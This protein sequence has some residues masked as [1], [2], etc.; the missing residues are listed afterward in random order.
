[1]QQSKPNIVFITSDQHRGDTLGCAGHPCVRTPHLDK[2]AMSGVRFDRAYADCPVCIPQRTT[3][4][5]GIQSH[6]YGMPEYA[7]QYRIDRPREL[8]LG[9]LLTRAGYQTQIVGKTH[10]HTE[11]TFR[12]GFEGVEGE[13][14]F[15]DWARA[16]TGIGRADRS[17]IGMNE[18]FPDWSHV[19][20][21]WTMTNWVMD[22]SIRFLEYRDRTQ[23]FFLWASVID[24]HPPNTVHE[25]Y[26]SMYDH[27][28]VPEPNVPEWIHEE[29]CPYGLRRHR[30]VWNSVRMKSKALRKARG[31]YYG[32]V[33]HID[34]QIGRLL[35][36]LRSEGQLDNTWIVYASDHGEMLGDLDDSG[37]STFME[38]SANVPLIICPPRDFSLGLGETCEALVGLDDLFATFCSIA[39]AETPADIT[40]RDLL[41]L[42]RGEAGEVR[43]ELH[44]QIGHSH[45]F[46]T[47]G[48]KYLYF[49]EDGKELLFD[50]VHDRL[51]QHPLNGNLELL[52]SVRE[53]F[54]AHLQEEGNEY[55]A[56]G[57]LVNL[58][59]AQQTDRE[60]RRT[61]VYGWH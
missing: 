56:D 49:A 9:S 35:G 21:E 55:V 16:R 2:L 23:P 31:V 8:F 33:T 28:D 39:G 44:G 14:E 26:Y 54:L 17:G 29:L 40:G 59:V 10:W 3:I 53:R 58:N 34:H 30:E 6:R 52:A 7:Q 11:P 42:I 41:P 48:Y 36:K 38:P 47:G 32:M 61:N 1:M 57:R 19:P 60:L 18:P 20:Q 24:P 4:V 5:T 27:E 25:P 13:A 12:G 43:H 37:K 51:E 45:M 15:N 22:R 46:H 50:A